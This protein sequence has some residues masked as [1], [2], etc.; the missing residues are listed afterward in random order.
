MSCSFANTFELKVKKG[1]NTSIL[2]NGD[3]VL[4]DGHMKVH[5]KIQQYQSQINCLVSKLSNGIE[6]ILGNNRLVQ[7][8]ACL[9]FQYEC[10]VV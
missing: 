6:L 4:I 5:A 8:I 1:N 3:R 10:C 7:H 9:D 2:G